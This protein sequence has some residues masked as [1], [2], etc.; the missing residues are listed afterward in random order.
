M[1][2][3]SIQL[4]QVI[5]D[6]SRTSME[7]ILEKG[8]KL[9]VPPVQQQ[10]SSSNAFVTSPSLSSSPVQARSYFDSYP[11]QH[12]EYTDFGDDMMNTVTPLISS[13]SSDTG[14]PRPASFAFSSSSSSSLSA[15]SPSSPFAPDSHNPFHFDAIP[16][17]QAPGASGTNPF[18]SSFNSLNPFNTSAPSPVSS[19]PA[20]DGKSAAALAKLRTAADE[21]YQVFVTTCSLLLSFI[22]EERVFKVFFFLSFF[23]ISWCS[24]LLSFF[25][26][27]P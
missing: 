3:R 26:F 27:L 10:Q 4:V 16:Q 22:P 13:P 20:P 21:R 19:V 1:L 15:S 24:N 5:I 9:A 8:A 7:E 11:M 12:T 25:F 2:Y 6:E 14:R 18:N 23:F 17:E